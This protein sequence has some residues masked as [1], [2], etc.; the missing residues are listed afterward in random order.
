MQLNIFGIFWSKARS[1]ED[2]DED[3]QLEAKEEWIARGLPSKD[4][5]FAK[6]NKIWEDEDKAN[7][8]LGGGGK[9]VKTEK[10]RLE[11]RE[12]VFKQIAERTNFNTVSP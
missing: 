8:G 1:A 3:I 10:E 5:T 7:Y 9:A 12:E 4:Y 11:E 2:V 6:M